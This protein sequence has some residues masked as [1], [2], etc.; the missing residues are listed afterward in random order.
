ML[1]G[2]NDHT[3]CELTTNNDYEQNKICCKCEILMRDI[4]LVKNINF[5]NGLSLSL[6]E[7]CGYIKQTRS[8]S[9]VYLKKHFLKKWL[10]KV[11]RL[12]IEDNSVYLELERYFISYKKMKVLDIGCGNGDKLLSFYNNK[13]D[14]YGVEPS[15]NRVNEALFRIKDLK[16]E[17]NFAEPYLI[18]NKVKF[19]IVIIYNVLQ[20]VKDPFFLLELISKNLTDGGVVYIRA[21]KYSYSNFY[22]LALSGLIRSYLS[23]HCMKEFILRNNFEILK[24]VDDPFTLILRKS[25]KKSKNYK[26]INKFRKISINDIKIYFEKTIFTPENMSSRKILIEENRKIDNQLAKRE[27]EMYIL[28][29]KELPL[30]L[31]FENDKFPVLLK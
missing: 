18:K 16:I 21:Q 10:S 26:N 6:C 22:Y 23:L 29:K 7:K 31:I 5:D 1:F 24:F 27:I 30:A 14:V 2:E 12:F 3:Y 8:L 9:D 17:N 13:H 25:E 19:D 28:S 20:F 15:I 11:K 4:I